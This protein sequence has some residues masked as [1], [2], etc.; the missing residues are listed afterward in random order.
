MRFDAVIS[1]DAES[2][3][4]VF[5]EIQEE[6]AKAYPDLNFVLAMDMDYGEVC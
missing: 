2:R 1:F 4:A 3:Q 6:L 5:A